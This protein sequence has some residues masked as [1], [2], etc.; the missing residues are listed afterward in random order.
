LSICATKFISFINRARVVT[1]TLSPQFIRAL[2]VN[3]GRAT[4]FVT[5]SVKRKEI[6]WDV[7]TIDKWDVVEILISILV[8]CIF[9]QCVWWDTPTSTLESTG[10]ISCLATATTA[11]IKLQ[12]VRPQI[13]AMAVPGL[14]QRFHVWPRSRRRP[15]PGLA[16]A[17]TV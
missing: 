7:E 1:T 11:T 17:Q 14:T 2:S 16:A 4:D 8:Q 6:H 3:I 12:P 9:S 13:R 5:S 15:P 10:T